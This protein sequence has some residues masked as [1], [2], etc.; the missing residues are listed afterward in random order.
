M[1]KY[2][3]EKCGK[4]FNQKSHITSHTHNIKEMSENIAK[5]NLVELVE[6]VELVYTNTLV[7]TSPTKKIHF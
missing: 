2:N 7:K 1:G 6:L 5:E 4:E 3:C